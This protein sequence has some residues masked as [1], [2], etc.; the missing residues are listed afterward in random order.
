MLKDDS[1]LIN[2]CLG[3][4]GTGKTVLALSHAVDKYFNESKRILLTKPTVMVS[5]GENNAFGPV[6]GPTPPFTHAD[7][8]ELRVPTMWCAS[9]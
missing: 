7:A 1:V 2:V 9:L 5:E 6:P 3:P 4:A 8:P